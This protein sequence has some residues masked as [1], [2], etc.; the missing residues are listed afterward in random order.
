MNPEVDGGW[1][2]HRDTVAQLMI[3][4][5]DAV[6]PNFARSVLGYEAISPLDLER[7]F[8]LVGGDIFHGALG[9]DQLFSS[10]PLLGQANYRA[11]LPGLYLCGSGSHP[12]GG[13]TGLPGRKC[14][15]RDPAR[16]A[17]VAVDFHLTEPPGSIL[18][19]NL[20]TPNEYFTI[21]LL[22]TWGR[23]HPRQRPRPWRVFYAP[24]FAECHAI[25]RR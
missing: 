17:R 22:P 18:R 11:A 6:A 5:V 21:G 24:D 25:I 20:H 16:R 4:T 13:V 12:G 10:R 7:R 9:L 15:A 14:G 2:A 1:D 8:G 3:D 19:R 23:E